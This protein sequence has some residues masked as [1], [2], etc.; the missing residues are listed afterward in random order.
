LRDLFTPSTEWHPYTGTERSPHYQHRSVLGGYESIVNRLVHA[1]PVSP[2]GLYVFVPFVILWMARHAW[3]LSQ[4]DD[5][6]SQARGAMLSLCLFNVIYVVGISSAVTFLESSRYRYQAESLIWVM[7]ALC[8]ASL[9][10]S[11]TQGL[12]RKPR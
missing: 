7:T 8:V 11:A 12:N 3:R 6:E 1:F 2:V 4:A 10:A 9:C 5:R